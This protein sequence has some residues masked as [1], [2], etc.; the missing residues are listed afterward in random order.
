MSDN[1][2]ETPGEKFKRIAEKRT[3]DLLHRIDLLGNLS[4]RLVYE[5]TEDQISQIFN[6]IQAALKQA[7]L[8]FEP[9]LQKKTFQLKK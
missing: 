3:S 7:K 4:N 9:N 6:A 8:K 2:K 5:Y 1:L